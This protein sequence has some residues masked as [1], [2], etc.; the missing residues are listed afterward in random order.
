MLSE[1]IGKAPCRNVSEDVVD[2][3]KVDGKA[4]CRNVGE[5]GVVD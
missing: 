3:V 5:S 4:P 2:N 1:L